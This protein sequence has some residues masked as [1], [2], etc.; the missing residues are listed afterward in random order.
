M[1]ATDLFEDDDVQS[2]SAPSLG[3]N[4][5]IADKGDK[6]KEIP[7]FLTKIYD[8]VDSSTDDLIEWGSDGKSF[9]VK[10]PK[11]FAKETLP[12]FFKT[13]NFN[14]F[15]RQ[16]NFYGFR[17]INYE[18]KKGKRSGGSGGGSEVVKL[19]EFQHTHFVRGRQDLLKN[20]KRKTYADSTAASKEELDT[21]RFEVEQRSVEHIESSETRMARLENLCTDLQHELSEMR[22]HY[23]MQEENFQSLRKSLTTPVVGLTSPPL[24]FSMPFA[25]PHSQSDAITNIVG[26]GGSR[27]R[28][29]SI[30]W[31]FDNVEDLRLE[32]MALDLDTS[33]FLNDEEDVID[34]AL[35]DNNIEPPNERD[36]MMDM[37]SASVMSSSDRS[38]PSL[39]EA[40]EEEP[41]LVLEEEPRV[42]L[43]KTLAAM[44]TQTQ[45][46][47][48]HKLVK[49]IKEMFPHVNDIAAVTASPA[50]NLRNQ[51]KETV[52][53]V[54]KSSG[55]DSS[56]TS[57]QLSS[58]CRSISSPA[59]GPSYGCSAV[60]SL[61]DPIEQAQQQAISLMA[62]LLP[63][64]QIPLLNIVTAS[65]I[66]SSNS[67]AQSS[68]SKGAQRSR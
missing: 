27:D 40:V 57:S 29:D 11:R 12:H 37:G 17:K 60:P 7:S 8:I 35:N 28:D 54:D 64:I 45:K 14:S 31:K 33:L 51:N 50:R 26:D 68:S 2:V 46:E 23:A 52:V 10:D 3:G 65:M 41:R 22:R 38:M 59:M 25:L 56:I 48:L 43:E 67:M 34:L 20:I 36:N 58:P 1:D 62:T 19:W 32:S 30:C 63:T 13:A 6:S 18:D 53:I 21:L 15:V 39:A 66:M 16:L 61:A 4:S 42:V 24:T 9:I 49:T 44:P 5:K 55:C 47:F